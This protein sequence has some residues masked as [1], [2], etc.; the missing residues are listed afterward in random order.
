[1]QTRPSLLLALAAVSGPACRGEERPAAAATALVVETTDRGVL[2]VIGADTLG[3][4]AR[5]TRLLP[6]PDGEAIAFTFADPARGVDAGL[7]ILDRGRD[8]AQLVWPN[9]VTTVWWSDA[10]R[11][12]FQSASGPGGVHAVVNVHAPAFE[13]IES[14]HDSVPARAAPPERDWPA[15]VRDRVTAYVDSLRVQPEGEPQEGQ[16]RYTVVSAL[17]APGDSIVAFYVIARGSPAERADRLNP[18]WYV[19][20]VHSGSVA[21]VDSIVGPA[22]SLPESAAAWTDATRFVYVKGGTVREAQ[23][24]ARGAQ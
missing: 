1:M 2:R 23:V 12:A 5:I 20:D 22:A 11:L 8:T 21:P 19:L 15:G 4:S 14:A 10:H 7:G 18:A 13:H 16:L 17:P 24:R 3:D 9:S 6:E